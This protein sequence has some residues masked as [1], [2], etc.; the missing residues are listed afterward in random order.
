MDAVDV[1]CLLGHWPFRKLY[2][3]TFT[4]LRRIHSE[5]GISYGCVSSLNSIFYNDPFEGDEELHEII[6]DT[7]YRHILTINPSLPAFEYDIERG[8][9]QFNILGVRIYPGYH[10]YTLNCEHVKTLCNVLKKNKLPLFLTLRMEDERI[11][12]IV[13]PSLINLKDIQAFI[14][15][16]PDLKILLLTIRFGEIMSLRDTLLN[17][18][19]VYFDTSGLKDQLFNI[20]K[21]VASL[22]DSKIMYGSLYPL[23]CLKSTLFEV[24]KAEI[25]SKSMGKILSG[26]FDLFENK[27]VGLGNIDVSPSMILTITD[28]VMGTS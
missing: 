28:K 19:N 24:T 23:F 26:N 25:V 3:N 18:S 10:D 20:E 9:N 4:D 22:G 15:A 1:N 6:N 21:L 16:N 12:Y 27:S 5:N 17:S 13:Q 8:V 2:K 14:E 7:D 11:N